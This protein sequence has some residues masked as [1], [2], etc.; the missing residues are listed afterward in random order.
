MTYIRGPIEISVEQIDG[1]GKY[2]SL[3][4]KSLAEPNARIKVASFGSYEKAKIFEMHL[5][6]LLGLDGDPG[7]P[8]DQHG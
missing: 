5:Q 7:G 4:I 3:W 1:F 8:D 6:K 2:P